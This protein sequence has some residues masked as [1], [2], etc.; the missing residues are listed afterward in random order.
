MMTTGG[1]TARFVT[2][3]HVP[4][5]LHVCTASGGTGVRVAI[6]Q[7]GYLPHGPKYAFVTSAADSF[8]VQA[9]VT[10][11]VRFRG[12][13]PIW[14]SGDPATGMNVRRGD[15]STFTATGTWVVVTSLADTSFP[16]AIQDTVFRPLAEGTLKG[17]FYQR[18]G[19][20]LNAS[21]AGV[22]ARPACHTTTDAWFHATA[23]S[24][25]FSLTTGGWHDAGDFGKYVV[26]AGISVG[27]LLLA[28][29]LWPTRFDRDDIGIP[30]SR[31]GIPDILDETRVELAWMLRMQRPD[32]GVYFKL[33][34]Q[35]FEAFVMPHNDAGPRYI[36]QVSSNATGDFAAVMAKAGRIYRPF[37]SLFATTCTAAAR[38]AWAFLEL[39]PSIV[40][41]GGFRN[42]AGTA[43]GEYGDGDDSD[44]RLW[45][46]AELFETTG[47]EP[48]NAAYVWGAPLNGYIS[49]PMWWGD[50]RTL[51]HLTYAFSVQPGADAVTRNAVRQS[52]LNQSQALLNKRNASGFHTALQVSEY[53]WG[54]NSS[55]LNAGI[56]LLLGYRLS[57]T[58]AYEDA[59][60]DQL[61]YVLGANGAGRSFV[62]GFGSRTP[63]HIHHR[64]SESDGI[65]NPV[66][67]LLAGGPN[68]YLSGDPVL[69]PLINA[70]T[71]PAL[72]YVDST[73]SYASNEIAINWNAP[74]VLLAGYFSVPSGTDDAPDQGVVP[75]QD[76]RLD[77]NYPNPFNGSTRIR[78][79][80]PAQQDVSI[81]VTDLLGR[82]VWNEQ[83]G[84]LAPGIHEVLWEARNAGGRSVSSGT[85]FYFIAG[86]T[87]SAV[88]RLV[89][90]R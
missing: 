19:T 16:F 60:A 52:L 22:Y 78:F 17:L 87:R 3:L 70:G 44:E 15:F 5:L 42:P 11:T 39:H 10:G 64:P 30:E 24:T 83:L 26:N 38:K 27:T 66:P 25:G 76:L 2:L 46:A 6:D 77:Q 62:T 8:T 12:P 34:K 65:L 80:I 18:C 33:T 75:P 32:G 37:D 40:P 48:F 23:E 72:C 69:D 1:R 57:G 4:L 90:L 13:L 47:E 82:A 74:L 84:V 54:S 36:Y 21:F 9:Q 55:A 50:V 63:M 68:K 73:P 43:T 89:V 35:N 61:H 49:A 14:K 86:D 20:A 58:Q 85:Y 56:L 79:F 7:A 53:V 88:R 45:A 31:N 59:A 51:A 41:A 71:P 67:G 81:R 29:E 28:Y